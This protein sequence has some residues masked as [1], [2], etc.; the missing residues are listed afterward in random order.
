MR[1]LDDRWRERGRTASRSSGQ[2]RAAR[3]L[4]D[5]PAEVR[6]GPGPHG[7]H[8][9]LLALVLAHVADVERR[10]VERDPPGV[11]QA[12][13]PDLRPSADA[14]RMGIAG[15]DRVGRRAVDVDPQELAEQALRILGPVLRVVRAAAVPHADVEQPVGTEPESAAVVVGVRLQDHEQDR[16]ARGIRLVGRRR[17]HPVPGDHRRAVR[18]ARV[19]DVDVG[20]RRER[21]VERDPEEPALVAREH[22]RLEVE[23]RFRDEGAVADDADAPGLLRDEEPPAAVARVDD[24]GRLLETRRDRD[25]RQRS[26]VG[27]RRDD[28]GEAGPGETRREGEQRDGGEDGGPG[29]RIVARLPPG[30]RARPAK[31]SSARRGSRAGARRPRAAPRAARAALRASGG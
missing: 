21:R 2:A 11:A 28:G 18:A 10:P 27:R 4:R 5:T 7:H 12:Q 1:V 25:E 15:R 23:E 31:A 9:E 22:Q 26:R 8:V 16:R 24:V 14:V 19:V 3:P 30:G 13:R 6:P 29:H 20:H 17:R